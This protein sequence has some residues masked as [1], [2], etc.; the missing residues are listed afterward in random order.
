MTQT[1][2]LASV[3]LPVLRAMLDQAI[4]KNYRDGVLGVHA[5]PRWDGPKEFEH[6]GIP[7]H[8][9]ACGSALAVREALLSRAPGRWLVVITDRD[10]Q[11]LGDGILAHFVGNRA[12]QPDE[13]EALRLRFKATGLDA[14]LFDGPAPRQLA[15]ALLAVEPESGWP[16]ATGGV[17]T[18]QHAMSAVAR[19]RLGIGDTELDGVAV[20]AWTCR[21]EAATRIAGLRASG[22]D[23]PTDAVLRWLA[24]RLGLAA[25]PVAALLHA[26][27]VA[28][29]VPLGLALELL[30]RSDLPVEQSALARE[31]LIRLEPTLGT[32]AG[33][34]DALRA[35]GA[36]A[37]QFA[38]TPGVDRAALAAQADTVL[39]TLRADAVAESSDL[40]PSGYR[41]RR[42][43]L[44]EAIRQAVAAGA[45]VAEVEVALI[46]PAHAAAVEVRWASVRQHE[47]ARFAGSSDALTAAVRLARWLAIPSGTEVDL[48]S[49]VTRHLDTDAWADA[50]INDAAAGLPQT[51]EGEA[52]EALLELA[53]RRRDAHDREFAQA[54]AALTHD[55]PA[56]P[57]VE[58]LEDVLARHVLPLAREHEHG[59]L[60]LVL[61]GMTAA[62]ATEIVTDALSHGWREA[63]P[64]HAAGRAGALA[65]LPTI[66]SVSRASLL[67]GQLC[68]GDQTAEQKGLL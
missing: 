61:D 43:Q 23:Q 25:S 26:G 5:Q 64:A 62:A 34:V 13:W 60:L 24:E 20:L 54:L 17:L 38:T 47:R 29:V 45:T 44:V 9:A 56:E 6:R 15:A 3:M 36:A 66:T 31:A 35:L 67:S 10:R 46:S 42:L 48:P 51:D 21:T 57:V 8:V 55:D 65:V 32:E 49:L 59:A 19:A 40:L 1:T 53:R 39:A 68:T 12:R 7:V 50:A 18:V 28:E 33:R 16:P 41:A 4:E 37:L 63:V 30:T 2:P 22:G 14:A 58:Y 52:V 27:R 11:D